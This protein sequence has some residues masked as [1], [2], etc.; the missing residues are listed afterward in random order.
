M[1]GE[2]AQRVALVCH[3]N[4]FLRGGN[5]SDFF[6]ANS[7]CQFCDGIA[8]VEFKKVF[9]GNVREQEIASN[10]NR[11]FATLRERGVHGLRL[12]Q[13]PRNDPNISDRMSAGF[14][15]GGGAWEI[16]AVKRNGSSEFWRSRWEV[17]N[18]N[19]PDKRIWRVAYGKVTEA[20]TAK[21]NTKP[22]GELKTYLQKALQEI[23][24]LSQKQNYDV[25]EKCFANALESLSSSRPLHGYHKDFSPDGILSS[26]AMALLD[27]CQAAWVFGGMGSWNDMGFDGDVELEYNRVS[28]NLFSLLT[29][30]IPAA[31]NDS[32]RLN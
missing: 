28:E 22:L 31:A 25:F 1:N 16:E 21:P 17:W 27:A 8:F 30:I 14:V 29:E 2:I 5:I 23:H 18:Q 3:G 15:G 13:T 6:P 20:K 24:S 12:S 10:P 4:T 7:T 32:F 19:A 26:D 11:W 9:F